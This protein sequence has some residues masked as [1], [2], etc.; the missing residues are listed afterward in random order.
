MIML[1]RMPNAFDVHKKIHIHISVIYICLI[2]HS[3]VNTT[4]HT[5]TCVCVLCMC[6]AF[7][8]KYI[9]IYVCILYV[10]VY[11]SSK[12]F[13][14]YL[15]FSLFFL[16]YCVCHVHY[17]HIYWPFVLYVP[18]SIPPDPQCPSRPQAAQPTLA[19]L[20][21]RRHSSSIDYR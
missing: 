5:Y 15:F 6:A 4:A 19:A 13:F 1:I 16:I 10:C 2:S 3:L 8:C 12:K 20:R 7:I 11:V 9:Y 18:S 14:L 17:S 21:Q